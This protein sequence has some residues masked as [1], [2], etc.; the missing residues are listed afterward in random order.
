MPIPTTRTNE[1]AT[2]NITSELCSGCGLCVTVCKDFSLILKDG[3][4]KVSNTP[5]FGCIGC[6][7][8]V[9][10]CPTDAITVEGRELSNTD[11]F[12]IPKKTERANYSQLMSLMQS[13][14]SV[15]DFKS[16]EIPQEI[17]EQ[18]IE[19]AKTAPMGLPPSDV[20]LLVI[21]GIEKN[22]EFASEF[23]KF[24]EKMRFMSKPWF[25]LLLKL[26]STKENH[27][28]FKEFITPVI[29]TFSK[30]LRE[31]NNLLT[32]DAPLALYF[33][34]SPYADPADPI[35]AATY[36]M[37]AGESLGLGSCMI[38]SIHPFIQSG[39]WAK[40]FRE[41]HG[42]KYKSRE[43]LFVIFGYP[44]IKYKKGIKRSFASVT[45]L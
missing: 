23:G 27:L 6:G 32:Y 44:R 4:V 9:A 16:V 24:L 1:N 3:K 36:A 2:I 41:S 45:S 33:Y 15:R 22:R 10:I 38:G 25:L 21:E 14:R 31:G 11:F 39:K 20:N 17:K 28:F 35:I 37:L 8:C 26:F 13:R 19:A 29:D 12:E 42:I 30:E 34:G 7:Q 5:I 18:I 40:R 43:G